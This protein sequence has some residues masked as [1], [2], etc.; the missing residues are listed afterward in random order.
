ME[1]QQ[2]T[3]TFYD[4]IV[5][6]KIKDKLGGRVRFAITG[7]APIESKV[8]SFLRIALSCPVL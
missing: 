1:N 6:S 4:A 2:F 5:F 8:L 3:S 7:S